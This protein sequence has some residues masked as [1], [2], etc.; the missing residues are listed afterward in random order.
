MGSIRF[1]RLF[2][3][4]KMLSIV[5]PVDLSRRPVN[6]L[7]RIR[8]IVSALR[9]TSFQIVIGHHDR[10][11]IFDWKLKNLLR[12]EVGVTLVSK[13]LIDKETSQSALRNMAVSHARFEIILLLD[14]DIYA[15]TDLLQYL[16][17]RVIAGESYVMAPCLYLTPYGTRR[18]IRKA[19]S[20]EIVE[21]FL[22][23]NRKEVLHLAIP[24]SII[25]MKRK[26]YLC[27]DGFNEAY[28]G[29]G[30]ED[31]DFMLRLGIRAKKIAVSAQLFLDKTYQAPLLA[32]GFRAVLARTCIPLVLEKKFAFH[33]WHPSNKQEKYYWR[34]TENS[35][36]FQSEAKKIVGIDHFQSEEEELP[37]LL[38]DFYRECMKRKIDP[39]DF[40]VLLHAVPGHHGR[41]KL[42]NW[43]AKLFL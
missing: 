40:N 3:K 5:I 8:N 19:S 41:P 12:E 38:R 37:V 39:A 34:R 10:G 28:R 35:E 36:I 30:Y 22:R 20:T 14:A 43:L 16:A 2:P 4:I 18:L 26:D 11:G 1:Q 23:F 29:Y 6:L 42:Q 25:A 32:E 33:L 17:D 21:N 24:S 13:F 27:M 31:F 9:K 15:D 7:M